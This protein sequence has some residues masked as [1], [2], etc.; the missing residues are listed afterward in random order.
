VPEFLLEVGCEEIPAAWFRPPV[1]LTQS[2]R[3][4]FMALA[5]EHRIGVGGPE[6]GIYP[7]SVFSTPRRLV[8]HA[9]VL[10]RQPDRGVITWGPALRAAK[11]G[12][13]NWTKAALGFATK[14]GITPDA[15]QEGIKDSDKPNDKYLFHE[16]RETGRP[17]SEVLPA[18]IAGTLRRIV[19]PKRMNWDAWL[20][21]GKGAFPFGRPIRWL[22]AI[23]DGTVIP[24]VVYDLVDGAQGQAKVAGGPATLGHRFLPRGEAGRPIVVRSLHD[25][26]SA[27]RNAFVLLDPAERASRIEEGL[28]KVVGAARVTGGQYLTAEWR[29]LAEYPTVVSGRIPSEFAHLPLEVSATVLEHHQKYIPI[30]E[31]SVPVARF[32]ALINSD[33]AHASEIVRGMERVVVARLRDASFFYAEDRKR[34]LLDRVGE[35]GGIT[36]HQGLGTYKEKTE[37]LVELVYAMGAQFNW[38]SRQDT[39]FAQAAAQVAKADLTTLMVREFPEL[40]GTTGGIY[41]HAEGA[42]RQVAEAVRWHY[43]PLSI[44][45]NSAPAEALAEGDTRVFASLSVADKIDTLA[46]YFGLGLNPTGSS[47]PYG[48]RRAAQGAVRAIVEFW[49]P[50]TREPHPDLSRLIER[51]VSGY[52]AQL[53]VPREK[54]V[55]ALEM[56]LLD[57]LEYL[58]QSRG[59]PAEETAAALY[60]PAV[61]ALA[62]PI[63]AFVRLQ[64]LHRVR[65]QSREDFTHLAVAFKRAKNILTQ[66][67]AAPVIEP[68]LFEHDAER[69]LHRAVS[70]LAGLNGDYESL[71][72]SLAGLRRPVDRFFDDV[73]VMAEDPKVRGNRLALLNE[74]LSLFYRI[75]DISKLG[76]QS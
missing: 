52:R 42:P 29:D 2:F 67:A 41:L 72:K 47:D 75:A 46:G 19:F 76:G 21:D 65:A 15:L 27:L 58:F 44:E 4:A 22:V 49:R 66:Q 68:R 8:L 69:E 5:Q 36:F 62:D 38:M 14:M 45:E 57:R 53:K 7:P 40:Q 60:T 70:G 26:Q 1:D 23:L 50:Q 37:R 6:G 3:A 10:D 17:A 63:D 33:H 71:L 11:D 20:E 56:F 32:A 73:L 54:V 59:Y 30:G 61:S 74:T 51:A 24:F 55:G 48:L 43:E 64:A 25:L 16:K 13:G 12:A 34:K 28:R 35:L 9:K 31:G 39:E 18:V